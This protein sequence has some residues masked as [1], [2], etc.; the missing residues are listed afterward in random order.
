MSIVRKIKDYVIRGIFIRDLSP[1]ET[2]KHRERF[3]SRRNTATNSNSPAATSH[4]S[5]LPTAP[6]VDTYSAHVQDNLLI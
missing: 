5:E 1:E 2:E 4:D 3:L 6:S